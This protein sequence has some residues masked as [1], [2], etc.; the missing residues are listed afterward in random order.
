MFKIGKLLMYNYNDEIY[1]YKFDSGI[2][3]FIGE[4]STGKTEFYKFIDYMFGANLSIKDNF[5]Y[6]GTLKKATMIFTYNHISY[7]ITRVIEDDKCF[8]SYEDEDDTQPIDLN[9]YKDRLQSVFVTDKKAIEQMHKFTDEHLTY[10]VFTLFSFLGEVRQGVL[11]DFFDKCSEPK[12]SIRIMSI[13]NFIF[14]KHVERIFL[15]QNKIPELRKAISEAETLVKTNDTLIYKVNINLRRLNIQ[16]TYNGTNGD[17]ILSK[18]RKLTTELDEPD[19]AK[20]REISDLE[21]ILSNLEE[22]I[23]VYEKY[24]TDLQSQEKENKNREVL[25]KSLRDIISDKAEFQYLVE[26]IIDLTKEIHNSVSFSQYILKDNMLKKLNKQR[27]DIKNELLKADSQLKR[28]T[29]DEKAKAIAIAED[30]IKSI[31]AFVS[32]DN[33]DRLKE[34]LSKCRKELKDLL[35]SNDY[36]KINSISAGV[37]DLYVSAYDSSDFIQDDL[38]DKIKKFRI[39]YIKS[40]NSLQTVVDNE[41]GEE[42]D[43]GT[44]SH[45]RHT[46]I[47]L[48]GYLIFMKMLIDENK[49]PIIP[50]LVIDHISKPFS[51][52]NILSIGAVLKNAYEM[53]G[54]ENMQTFI[55]DDKEPEM[56]GITPSNKVYLVEDNKT[57]FNPFFKSN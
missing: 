56:L 52:Q 11:I 48:C 8:F 14:N 17:S 19:A 41:K 18:L 31:S 50:M 28:Y 20:T 51:S 21:I 22:Q 49:Y 42:I 53:I 30:G 15:L 10:R 5:W 54:T 33:L 12:Y 1:T 2:N 45:A 34:E 3:Y 57:G 6:K 46:L 9:E 24:R 39:K 4:N 32:D 27:E 29:Y 40:K 13:L 16:D 23:K 55:F 38:N 25:L 44:G 26:P 43:Y 35:N 36:D 47:Q 37:T 7:R